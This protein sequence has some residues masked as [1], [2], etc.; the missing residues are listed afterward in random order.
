MPGAGVI[1]GQVA[2]ASHGNP[3]KNGFITRQYLW[4]FSLTTSLFFLWGFAYGLLDVLN[5]H[6]RESFHGIDV[7][8]RVSLANDLPSR[9][10]QK[11]LFMSPSCNRP[12][13]RS[14]TSVSDTLPTLPS[15]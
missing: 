2:G 5:K 13:S 11:T 10:V 15:L 9:S 8:D 6:F 12:D 14:P 3:L 4:A 7:L 1:T